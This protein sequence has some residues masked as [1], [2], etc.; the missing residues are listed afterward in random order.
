[1]GAT[2]KISIPGSRKK[3]LCDPLQRIGVGIS[4]L[5]TTEATA[6][7]AYAFALHGLDRK[8]EGRELI[9]L[10]LWHCVVKWLHR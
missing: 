6:I 3:V 7:G 4:P 8:A 9:V 1:M 5:G 10:I 2:C